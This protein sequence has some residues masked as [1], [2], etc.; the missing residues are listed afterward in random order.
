MDNPTNKHETITDLK[1]EM[2]TYLVWTWMFWFCTAL[3]TAIGILAQYYPSVIL[4]DEKLEI[5]NAK[6][7]IIFAI[8][9]M[10]TLFFLYATYLTRKRID[11][12][13]THIARILFKD[14]N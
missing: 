3:I 5:F 11:Q 10:V 13:F 12:G 1:F 4:E 8:S 6:F 7:P 9:V 2:K 14:E